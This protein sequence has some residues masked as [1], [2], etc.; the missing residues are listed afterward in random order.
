MVKIFLDDERKVPGTGWLHAKT[1]E[2]AISLIKFYGPNL[3]R[4]S[5]DHDLGDG[6][7]TG[8][9]VVC[10]LEELHHEG[11]ISSDLEV[12]IH[13]ANPSGAD[14]MA[15]ACSRMFDRPKRSF[16]IDYFNLLE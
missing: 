9:D 12:T 5:L 3:T 7:P 8:Y 14:R 1:A 4:L 10:A 15:L 16:L 13:S 2:E 11:C 6:V